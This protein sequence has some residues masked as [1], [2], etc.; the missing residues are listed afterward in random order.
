MLCAR[1]RVCVDSVYVGSGCCECGI[2]DVTAA[3]AHGDRDASRSEI[4]HNA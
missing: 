1:A 3:S 4:A 2:T